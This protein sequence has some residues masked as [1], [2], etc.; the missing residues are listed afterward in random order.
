MTNSEPRRITLEIYSSR[1]IRVLGVDG[2]ECCE[3][4]Q[5][6]IKALYQR[7]GGVNHIGELLYD[8]QTARTLCHVACR[9]FVC[10]V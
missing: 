8:A 6:E 9:W 5:E 7:E 1:D 10:P 3:I 4:P 2:A